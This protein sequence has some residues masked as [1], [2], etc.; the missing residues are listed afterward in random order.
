MNTQFHS[1]ES[2]TENSIVTEMNGL[3]GKQSALIHCHWRPSYGSGRRAVGMTG[4]YLPLVKIDDLRQ[5]GHRRTS[6]GFFPHGARALNRVIID[7]LV[8]NA[9]RES[10]YQRFSLPKLRRAP[11]GCASLT[12]RGEALA[13][14]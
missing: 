5:R 11:S 7:A 6:S 13:N 4:S 3:G 10:G 9:S 2:I 14:D 8:S 12:G 1:A